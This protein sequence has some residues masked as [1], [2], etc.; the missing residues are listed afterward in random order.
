VGRIYLDSAATTQIDP[1]VLREVSFHLK[2]TFGNAGSIH[3]EGV[4]A[5]KVLDE[6]RK[7]I[8]DFFR[9]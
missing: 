5:K 3:E 1:R 9:L 2:N 8:A 7:K 6:S 4:T